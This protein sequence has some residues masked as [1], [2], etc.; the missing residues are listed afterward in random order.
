MMIY[1]N[2]RIC[3]TWSTIQCVCGFMQ[4]FWGLL[5]SS[6]DLIENIQRYKGYLLYPLVIVCGG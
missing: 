1:V 6:S 3:R 2:K 5:F 4:F